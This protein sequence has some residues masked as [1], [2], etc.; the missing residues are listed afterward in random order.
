MLKKKLSIIILI[1][2]LAAFG[3]YFSIK[4]FSGADMRQ[5]QNLFVE[6]ADEY[7]Q[8]KLYVRAIPLYQQALEYDTD[9][10]D[11]IQRKLLN[12]YAAYG[13]MRA[14]VKLAEYRM[15]ERLAT[16]EEYRKTAEYYMENYQR[17]E[18][19][20][21]L[22]KG[23]EQLENETLQKYYE[24]NR[25]AYDVTTTAYKEIVPTKDNSLMPAYD[26]EKWVYIDEY[27]R[28][29]KIGKFESALPFNE[30]GYAVVRRN[31]Q[32]QTILSNGDLYG[33]DEAGAEDVYAL[34]SSRVL[35]KYDGKY[36]YYN[37]DFESLT[38]GN[39][40]YLGITSNHDGVAAV[41]TESGWGII[42][43]S[44]DVVVDFT[45]KDVAVNSLNTAFMGG[46]AMVKGSQGWYL[47]DTQGNALTEQFYT[48]ARAPESA[49]GYIAVA[50]NSGKWGFID[51]TGTLI[52]ACQYDDAKSFS[53]GV[54]AVC[55][56]K[57]WEYISKQNKTV[58]DLS[59]DMAQPFHEGMAQAHFA[60]DTI[61]IRLDY[62][63]E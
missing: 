31:G 5:Q 44:G 16:A 50:D 17:Q 8:K 26:G 40:Q 58:I 21:I 35:A 13:D 9:A 59:L 24:E 51:T 63:E 12:T 19:M 39:H 49:E 28:E 3:W 23:A 25:Y 48:D 62:Y 53:N 15:Q 57:R 37:Y 43:D 42:T 6:Q 20:E 2:V 34:S 22:K 47:A 56:G 29:I 46:H 41:Q 36:S 10:C 4:K 52:I 55:L 38:N 11:E 14:Y 18:A 7:A 54:A 60:D 32:Y 1:A 45:L 33:I 61:L 30:E 27:A